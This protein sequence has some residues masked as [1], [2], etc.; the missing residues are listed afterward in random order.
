MG[1]ELE[2]SEVLGK[3]FGKGIYLNKQIALE[4]I[5]GRTQI[6]WGL[7]DKMTGFLKDDTPGEPH[8]ALATACTSHVYISLLTT[9]TLLR[10]RDPIARQLRIALSEKNELPEPVLQELFPYFRDPFSKSVL[11]Y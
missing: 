7:M 8:T 6:S 3:I 5:S 4:T 1:Y 2:F 10:D 9:I 11:V